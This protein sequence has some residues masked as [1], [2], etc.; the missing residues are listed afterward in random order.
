M[1]HKHRGHA[2]QVYGY[3]FARPTCRSVSDKRLRHGGSGDETS[4][5]QRDATTLYSLT[6]DRVQARIQDLREEGL[7]QILRLMQRVVN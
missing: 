1:G 4:T 5:H 7:S 3:L 6:I 2:E